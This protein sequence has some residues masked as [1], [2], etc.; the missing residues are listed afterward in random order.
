MYRLLPGPLGRKAEG[1]CGRSDHVRVVEAGGLVSRT[2]FRVD[3]LGRWKL[4]VVCVGAGECE[5]WGNIVYIQHFLRFSLGLRWIIS[6]GFQI[7]DYSA[8]LIVFG[9][10]I[11]MS[12]KMPGHGNT[13]VVTSEPSLR[14]VDWKRDPGLRQLYFWAFILCIASAT[15]GYDG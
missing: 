12:G 5:P 8:S 9:I 1:M 10:A 3:T 6:G 14:R 13:D 2:V 11:D 7:C 15:T 4:K